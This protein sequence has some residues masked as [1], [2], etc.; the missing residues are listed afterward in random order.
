MAE[1]DIDWLMPFNAK[2]DDVWDTETTISS[3]EE[4]KKDVKW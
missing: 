3:Y 2:T 1:Y 4:I